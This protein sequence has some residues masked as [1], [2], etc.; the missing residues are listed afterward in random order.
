MAQKPVAKKII[1]T[2]TVTPVEK[3][4]GFWHDVYQHLMCGIGHMVPFVVAGGI[5]L[6]IAYIIDA[7]CGA[8]QGEEFGNWSI[9][10]KIFHI[11]GGDLGLG[12]MLPVLAGFISYSIAGKAGLAAGF[13]G[14]FAA[15]TGPFSL[16]YWIYYAQQGE[17]GEDVKL[18][19]KTSAGFLGALIAGFLA[20]YIV[21][22]IENK[23]KRM[24]EKAIPI[25]DILITPVLSVFAIG[26]CMFLINVPLAY[27]NLGI[28]NGLAKLA[29]IQA[30]F[31][32][33][34]AL[35]AGL[36]AI[37]MGGPINKATHLFCMGILA[38]PDSQKIG[39]VLL[40]ANLLGMVTPP[41]GIALASWLF[42][43]KF[44]KQDRLPS[45]ANLIVG[46]CGISEG[47]IPYVIKDPARTI[48]SCVVGAACGGVISAAFDFGC[49][50][51]EGGIISMLASGLD[52]WKGIVAVIIGTIITALLLGIL[53]RPV[54]PEE[55]ELGKWKGIPFGPGVGKKKQLK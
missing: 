47:A 12:L 4:K 39:M 32:F 41:A 31:L 43:Q 38:N 8:P 3:K 48:S 37:D 15:K 33:L 21:L 26:V 11:L 49:L 20:G 10:A 42:P 27:L 23:L 53:R 40:A 6:A 14:G 7:A 13:I 25:K 28:A 19:A 1:K 30:A 35:V 18:L 54:K 55:A 45:A 24:P 52:A 46:M 29:E 34:A 17:G 2:K 16:I 5:L 36:M 50:A 44:T 22:F 51:P 9:G